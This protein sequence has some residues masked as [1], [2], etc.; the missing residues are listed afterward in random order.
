[1]SRATWTVEVRTRKDTWVA[2]NLRQRSHVR[3]VTLDA[4][5]LVVQTFGKLGAVYRVRNT[6]T[7]ASLIVIGTNPA[8]FSMRTAHLGRLTSKQRPFTP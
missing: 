4:A 7:E 8:G 1:M 5:L 2:C 3:R 6:A